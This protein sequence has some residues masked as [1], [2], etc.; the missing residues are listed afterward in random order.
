MYLRLSRTDTAKDLIS[1]TLDVRRKLLGPSGYDLLAIIQFTNI[2][3]N[4]EGEQAILPEQQ[5][6]HVVVSNS[7]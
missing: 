6:V 3:I 7:V 4:V 2:N 1:M 5:T